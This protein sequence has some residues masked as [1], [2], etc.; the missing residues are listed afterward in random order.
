MVRLLLITRNAWNNDISTGNTMSNFLSGF[1]G[2]IASL[3]C[4]SEQINNSICKKYFQIT[5]GQLIKNL[6]NKK[7]KVGIERL[8]SSAE[9]TVKTA[10]TKEDA[11][12]K[13]MYGYL[14]SHR[15]RLLIWARDILWKMGRW[16]NKSLDDFL[17]EFNPNV[18]FM[19]LY[20]SIYMYDIMFY[21][22]KQTGAKIVLY[23]GDDVY[24]LK[25]ISR[26]PF[27]WIDRFCIRRKIRKAVAMS[28]VR[29]S[30][31]NK[32][33]EEYSRT[34]KKPFKTYRKCVEA[35]GAVSGGSVH[36]PIKIAYTGNIML[37]RYKTIELIGRALEEINKDS[38]K[39]VLD[40]YTA[41]RLTEKMK[42]AFDYKGVNFCGAVS[43]EEVAKIQN[44]AD[45]LLHVEG[46]SLKNRL[47]VRL[48]LSTKIVDYLSKGKC[49]LA[50][51]PGDVASMEYLEKNDAAICVDDKSKIYDTLMRIIENNDMIY[52]YQQ[53]AIECIKNNHNE[54][55][56]REALYRDF[57]NIVN[58]NV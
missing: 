57:E 20:D 2:E 38:V 22:K 1:D 55:D 37:G 7:C 27:F 44:D 3:Y 10:E 23:T 13:K 32:Q 51:A 47:T 52:E 21:V 43:S 31:T 58:E 39:M 18:I 19:P 48:S 45:I 49:V 15:F 33:S 12:S 4:R 11:T 6:L 50:V 25:R 46:F 16:K 42:K 29:F 8:Y 28:D 35:C 5:E 41:N 24:S 26:S 17:K 30:L 36:N 40:V 14:K 34:L 9:T 53:K 54:K 56:N